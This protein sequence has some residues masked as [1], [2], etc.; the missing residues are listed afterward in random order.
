M[1]LKDLF[2][3]KESPTFVWTPTDYGYPGLVRTEA[4]GTA[5]RVSPEEMEYLKRNPW[6]HNEHGQAVSRHKRFVDDII[7]GGIVGGGCSAVSHLCSGACNL[8]EWV[9]K[10][11]SDDARAT[12]TREVLCLGSD[13]R[14]HVLACLVACLRCVLDC[15]RVR[16]L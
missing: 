3:K 7:C 9:G 5:R 10:G 16:G 13:H 8:A 2:R 1:G 4:D 6:T 11:K 15:R 12:P 14:A